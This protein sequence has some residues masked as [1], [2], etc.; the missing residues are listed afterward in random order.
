MGYNG[1]IRLP[2]GRFAYEYL[3]THVPFI[4][5][6]P[7]Y[8][9]RWTPGL[10]RRHL[11]G[12]YFSLIGV[13]CR[14]YYHWMHDVLAQLHKVLEWLPADTRIIVP[15]GL[16]KT[17][18]QSLQALGVT[19]SRLCYLDC[20]N[21]C[22]DIITVDELYFIPPP[23][24]TRFD[25]PEVAQWLSARLRAAF[26]GTSSVA[27]R[28][29]LRLYVSR[30]KA[31]CRRVVNEEEILALLRPLGFEVICAEDLSLAR[32]A[33]CFA[34]A[35]VVVAPHGA[36]LTNL[37]FSSPGTKVIEILFEPVEFRT[38]YWSL[39]E[40]LGMEYIYTMGDAVENKAGLEKDIRLP[41]SKLATALN[42]AGITV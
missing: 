39:C 22:K 32:Q 13:F 27:G 12:S 33:S 6:N 3:T 16:D 25:D 29:P 8:F 28:Q 35:E 4:T 40:A 17:Q 9:Q 14:A 7:S 10:R 30:A 26:A 36:G 19:E 1:F 11:H 42:L 15:A 41:P 24:I 2:D 20:E 5:D 38:C 31:A 37:Y 23:T 34:Q 18:T 21:D